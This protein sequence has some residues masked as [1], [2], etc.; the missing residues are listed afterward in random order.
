[1]PTDPIAIGAAIFR[2]R[3]G[4]LVSL[5]AWYRLEASN[6]RRVRVTYVIGIRIANKGPD[7]IVQCHDDSIS[8]SSGP[9]K[10]I[11]KVMRSL[12]F[13]MTGQSHPASNDDEDNDDKLDN[14]KKVLKA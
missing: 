3:V 2:V 9:L 8:A 1:M 10:G 13:G 11:G 5:R 7:D 4:F 14:S 12:N 6:E